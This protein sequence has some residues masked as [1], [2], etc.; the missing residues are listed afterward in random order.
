MCLSEK[1]WESYDNYYSLDKIN[2]LDKE[3]LEASL[4]ECLD[5]IKEYKKQVGKLSDKE[6]KIVIALLGK[7]ILDRMI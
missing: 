4:T 3:T 7:E 1:F 5:T 2:G 6:V